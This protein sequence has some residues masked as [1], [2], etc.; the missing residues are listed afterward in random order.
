MKLFKNNKF[1]LSMIAL[2]PLSTSVLAQD[3]I[4]LDAHAHDRYT[5]IK[6]KPWKE[7]QNTHQAVN[8]PSH[9][10]WRLFVALNWPANEDKCRADRRKELGDD[11]LATW[12]VWQSKEE[13]FLEGAQKPPS[14]KNGCKDGNFYTFPVGEFSVAAD[15]AVRLNKKTYDYIRGNNLYS[16]DEQ[17]RLAKA[18][19]RD[20]DFPLGAKEVK[21][22]WV[23]I[24]EEDKSRYHWMER[25][26]DGK[27]VIYGLSAFHIISKD[28]PTWFWSTFEHVDNESRWPSVYPTNFRGW[29]VPSFDHAACPEDNLSC[30]AIPEG[31]GL[32]G[33]KWAN[34]RLRGTQSTFVDNR[35]NPTILAN[36]HLEGFLDQ[37][38]MSCATCHAL[39]VKGPEGASMPL[40]IVQDEVNGE[41]F[42]LGFVGA[43][44]PN[45]FLDEYG[46]PISYLGLDYVFALRNA[47]REAKA[48]TQN[49]NN[50]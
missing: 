9:Y 47:K 15:E 18:G 33:T 31:Y 8:N 2:L 49:N 16:L 41:G 5:A 24:T 1:L 11:G 28:L 44:D 29:V 38:T 6:G 23:T 21:A 17:E 3:D 50:K 30:N 4:T 13:T 32:E 43:L 35:G 37:P 36:S 34:Y 7:P 19:V 22:G 26:E 12:E 25:V 20:L 46:D 40:P 14:W 42:P 39:S 48:T 27:T 10:A 45:M